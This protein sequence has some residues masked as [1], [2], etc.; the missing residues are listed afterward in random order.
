[1]AH[2]IDQNDDNTK[3]MAHQ[4]SEQV[5]EPWLDEPVSN[6][7]YNVHY[8]SEYDSI[9]CCQK[10]IHKFTLVILVITRKIELKC[11]Y[12]SSRS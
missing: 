2:T 6:G 5:H 1:M 7:Y 4:N 10:A 11:Q 12:D 3:A 9:C 8:I